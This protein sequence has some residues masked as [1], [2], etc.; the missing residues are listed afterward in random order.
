MTVSTVDVKLKNACIE[1]RCCVI[2]PPKHRL[3]LSPML[4]YYEWLAQLGEP[5][6]GGE[7]SSIFTAYG[8]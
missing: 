7:K 6:L 8:Y 3:I 5:V 4:Q 2:S 1:T